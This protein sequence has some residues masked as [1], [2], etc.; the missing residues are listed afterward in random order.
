MDTPSNDN[1]LSMSG[2]DNATSVV[3]NHVATTDES[4]ALR[5]IDNDRT[6][7]SGSKHSGAVRLGDVRLALLALRQRWPITANMRR[8]LVE[9]LLQIFNSPSSGARSRGIAAKALATL[10]AQNLQA[11]QIAMGTASPSVHVNTVV[12]V[13]SIKRD[14]QT[15]LQELSA[16]RERAT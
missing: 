7:P 16:E 5:L 6:L 10:N 14:A 12:N 11:I 9:G 13:D 15:L 3:T 1:V 4:P 8:E 2:S